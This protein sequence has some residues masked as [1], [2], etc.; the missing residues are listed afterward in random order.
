MNRLQ[1]LKITADDKRI[2]DAADRFMVCVFLGVGKYAKAEAPDV[3]SAYREGWLLKEAHGATAR[4]IVYAVTADNKTCPLNDAAVKYL[5]N[6]QNAADAANGV[7]EMTNDNTTTTTQPEAEKIEAPAT[8]EPKAAKPAKAPKA[9][10]PAKPAAA[11]KPAKAKP[12]KAERKQ[13]DEK[14]DGEALG[15]NMAEGDLKP[16]ELEK[17]DAKPAK[18][19][20]DMARPSTKVLEAE[21]KSGRMPPKPDFSAPTHARFRKKLDEVIALVEAGD[22]AGLKAY[23]INPIS[24]S[25]KAIDRYRNLAV[26][27]LEAKAQQA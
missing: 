4:P 1:A 8:T 18:S 13:M 24:S 2:I 9:A 27:A 6:Q 10:K 14:K 20:A 22:I 3:V 11:A 26:I 21:A 15:I 19:S 23:Q 25:P 5:V 17:A 7:P 12:T 16:V